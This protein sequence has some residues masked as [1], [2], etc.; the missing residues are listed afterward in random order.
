MD[1]KEKADT[2]IAIANIRAVMWKGRVDTSWKIS[3]ALWALL[4]ATAFYVRQKAIALYLGPF[5]FIAHTYLNVMI[6]ARTRRE[7]ALI[8]DYLSEIERLALGRQISPNPGKPTVSGIRDWMTVVFNYSVAI[9]A[10]AT[11]LILVAMYIIGK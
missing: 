9:Q 5:V 11:A 4:A 10:L 8:S 1:D 7:L 6:S 2:L 3:L